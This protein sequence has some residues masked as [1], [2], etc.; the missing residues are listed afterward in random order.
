MSMHYVAIGMFFAA[1]AAS[2]FT[3]GVPPR[4]ARV[5]RPL[6]YTLLGLAAGS[7]MLS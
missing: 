2:A 3:F 6:M 1:I 4:I 7:Y 5:M